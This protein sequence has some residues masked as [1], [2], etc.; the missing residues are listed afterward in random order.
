M[1][2]LNTTVEELRKI[3]AEPECNSLEFK[4]AKTGFDFQTLLDYCCA[5]ANE[6]GGKLVLGVTNR[7]PRR[8]VGTAALQGVESRQN[9]ILYALR[10]RVDIEEINTP[11]GRVVLVHIPGRPFGMPITRD[12]RYLMRAGESLVPMSSDRLRAI[13]DETGPDYSALPCDGATEQDLDSTAIDR[14]RSMWRRKSNNRAI[15]AL[16]GEQ[17]CETAIS[18]RTAT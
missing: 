14:L 8:I 6:E 1:V 16:H 4:E 13:Y 9:D 15:D 2:H 10:F 12:G 7:K 5:I 11:E 17:C 3:I 18:S